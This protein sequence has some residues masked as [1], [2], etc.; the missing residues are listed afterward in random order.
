M[1]DR[2]VIGLLIGMVSAVAGVYLW[3]PLGVPSLDP[4]LRLFG[5][6][7][8][9]MPSNSMVPTITLD[10]LFVASVWPYAHH[11]PQARDVV[12]FRYPVDPSVIYV[13]RIVA[14]Q[15]DTVAIDGCV[16]KVNGTKLTEPYISPVQHPDSD[17]CNTSG[18]VVPKGHFFVLG[19]AR[20][21]SADSR[22]WGFV[23]SANII[24]RAIG[25]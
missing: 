19:D 14:L 17:N 16:A 25:Y 13:K 18:V 6:S 2:I 5:F 4:R 23:P 12:V 24:G 22:S 10:T 7:V 1:S 21:N 3:N 15:G 11:S 8:Y 9:R 20:E